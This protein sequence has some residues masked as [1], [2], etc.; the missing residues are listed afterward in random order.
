MEEDLMHSHRVRRFWLSLILG[1]LCLIGPA[2]AQSQGQPPPVGTGGAMVYI[3]TGTKATGLYHTKDCPW[4]R[5]ANMQIFMLHEA[6][7]RYF[8]PHC[9]CIVGKEGTP[10]CDAP[11]PSASPAPAK[12]ATPP[13]PVASAVVEKPAATPKVINA[14]RT[15]CAATTKKGV[16]CSRMAEPGSAYCWQ[17]KK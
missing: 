1:L 7:E 17:H 12:A 8:Q 3:V 13:P 9:L 6:K 2:G 14:A 4:L 11:L 15:Q 16:R 10:P 5:D